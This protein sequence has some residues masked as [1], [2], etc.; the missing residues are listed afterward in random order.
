MYFIVSIINVSSV[1]TGNILSLDTIYSGPV[2]RFARVPFKV[3]EHPGPPILT[4][5]FVTTLPSYHAGIALL[6]MEA[7]FVKLQFSPEGNSIAYLSEPQINNRPLITPV[8]PLQASPAPQPLPEP[9]KNFPVE[10]QPSPEPPKSS[11]EE[12]PLAYYTQ[13]RQEERPL[14]SPTFMDHL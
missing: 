5:L 1:R 2:T 3:P 6:W 11:R 10:H 7:N 4:T 12:R 9:L 8:V 13:R 14:I